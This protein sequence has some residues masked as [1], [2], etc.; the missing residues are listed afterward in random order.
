[1]ADLR[2]MLLRKG[3]GDVETYIK[4]GNVVLSSD[5]DGSAI[6]ASV[7]RGIETHFGF[8]V[9][10]MARTA[11]EMSALGVTHQFESMGLDSR[12]LM[13]AFFDRGA[14]LSAIEDLKSAVVAPDLV[15]VIG[16]EAYL[17]YPDGAGRSKLTND[18]LERR[19]LLRST[20]RNWNTVQKLVGLSGSVTRPA[21]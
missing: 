15:H 4:S 7:E 17:A 6:V 3:F 14:D 12:R 10:V 13:V 8:S 11:H 9:D 21:G 1:M 18:L 5:L 16:R 20:M 19:L 2:E